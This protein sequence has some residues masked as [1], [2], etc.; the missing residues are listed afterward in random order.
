MGYNNQFLTPDVDGF[1]LM[2]F[3]AF[4]VA[5]GIYS[6][7]KKN[8]GNSLNRAE[9]A[10]SLGI[11]GTFLGIVIG[12]LEFDVRDIQGSIP[13]LL[14]GLKYA[15]TTS[16]CGMISSIVIKLTSSK[17]E[18]AGS[19]ASPESIQTELCKI[20]VTLQGNNDLRTEESNEL[21]DEFKKLISGDN[22]TS[23]VNQIK[24]MK[25]DLIEQLR[26]NKVINESGFKDL[27]QNLNELG[28]NL[29]EL[30]SEAMVEALEQAIVEFNNQLADQ[31][32]DN[33]KELNTG[34]KNLLEW[35][36]EY[37]ETIVETQTYSKELIDQL[38]NAT[39]AIG[40][41]SGSLEPIPRTVQSIKDLFANTETSIGLLTS[42]LESFDNMKERATNA[43]PVIEDNI[44]R[45]TEGFTQ[46]INNVGGHLETMSN[47][48][49]ES[50]TQ[51]SETIK[52]NLM[53]SSELITEAV[54]DSSNRI[55]E[56]GNNLEN[57]SEIFAES[58]TQNQQNMNQN[59][60]EVNQNLAESITQNQQN[61]N[62]HIE[63]VNQNLAE[64]ITQNQQ[65]MNQNIEEV[66][67]NL[68]ESITQ[69][70]QNVNQ[71]IE[72]A[73][74]N[75]A[76]SITQNQQNMNQ[77]IEEVNQ[78]L[79]ETITQNQQNVNHNIEEVNQNLAESI[80]Q[81]QQNV[82]QNIE[83]NNQTL[84]NS[85]TENQQNMNRHL[86]NANNA[87]ETLIQ[88][89][90]ENLDEQMQ[91]EMTGSINAL[92]TGLSSLSNKFVNDYEPLTARMSE[93]VRISENIKT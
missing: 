85:I 76:E 29:A 56:A 31:L 30:S 33:F 20:N 71:N 77:N 24:L 32:G 63:E 22:D 52:D 89:T 75:L 72:E 8:D 86:E 64:S 45:M 67:Q 38:G 40:N 25:G 28:K 12:L 13:Q 27:E 62:Q 54:T 50:I 51:N 47:N 43:F 6:V 93:L 57:A 58:I 79:A 18:V 3:T 78:N 41:I 5:H 74:Q 92:G 81:N 73:N 17:G 65:N 2:L 88:Q 44:T 70:Q 68:A 39:S 87:C 69:N 59:I 37:K 10:L 15:F 36:K 82:N 4:I 60:E 84:T 46:S 23:L 42:T 83:A 11:L 7:F 49:S 19:S 14:S 61:V 35:Q 16:I 1:I 66:N 26:E 90:V 91:I 48:F 34:V 53:E 80:T 55:L 21:K 9:M